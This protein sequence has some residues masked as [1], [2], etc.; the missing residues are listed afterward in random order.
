MR[1]SRWGIVRTHNKEEWEMNLKNDNIEHFRNG[2]RFEYNDI[3]YKLGAGVF[4]LQVVKQGVP[5]ITF[6]CR[7]LRPYPFM[8]L[9]KIVRGEWGKKVD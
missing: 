5:N 3:S 4:I 1:I 2:G 9:K 8:T 6:Y 7:A